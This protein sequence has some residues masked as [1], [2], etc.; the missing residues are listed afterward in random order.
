MNNHD[1]NRNYFRDTFKVFHAPKDI[2]KEVLSMAKS[3]NDTDYNNQVVQEGVT[4]N[5]KK[6][7]LAK[8]F[9]VA[10]ALTIVVGSGIYLHSITNRVE[11]GSNTTG[12]IETT[13]Q[14]TVQDDPQNAIVVG[15][16]D[17]GSNIKYDNFMGTF[18]DVENLSVSYEH[19]NDD[20]GVTSS[21]ITNTLT[22]KEVELINQAIDL[23]TCTSSNEETFNDN[24]PKYDEELIDMGI[25]LDSASITFDSTGTHVIV[26]IIDKNIA[27]YY[28]DGDSLT[29]TD[30]YTTNDTKLL[31]TISDIVSKKTTTEDSAEY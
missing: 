15:S 28:Y 23:A 27:I 11:V 18:Y 9:A 7:L 30:Y 26:Y 2:T 8:C 14:E 25:S 3:L 19:R 16:S 13:T 20:M 6:N 17:N 12:S 31:N 24:N 4:T 1:E 21:S 22:S 10:C 5:T 29:T